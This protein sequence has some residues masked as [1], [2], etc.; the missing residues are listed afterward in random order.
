MIRSVLQRGK[1]P[2]AWMV[3]NRAHFDDNWSGEE[4]EMATSLSDI[5][6]RSASEEGR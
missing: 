4:Q 6:G 5:A 2:Y 3:S 1:H